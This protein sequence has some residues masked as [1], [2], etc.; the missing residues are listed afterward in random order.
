M[1]LVKIKEKLSEDEFKELE[2]HVAD[3]TGQR[4]AARRESID[5]RKALRSRVEQLEGVQSKL[6]ERLG[7]LEESEIESLPDAKG[8]AEAMKQYEARM[9][10]LEKERDT[11]TAERDALITKDRDSR[12]DAAI[13]ASL[14]RDA[15]GGVELLD[16]DLVGAFVRSKVEWDGDALVYRKEDGGLYP[17]KDAVQE[18]VKSKPGWVKPAGNGS[19]SNFQAREGHGKSITRAQYEQMSPSARDEHFKAGG[20]LTD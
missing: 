15:L 13:A 3:L 19:G 10:K 16:T 8:Q 4:D 12:R 17:V 6:F 7:I 1:D 5:G 20:R 14:A 2:T 18:L 9:K 11:L